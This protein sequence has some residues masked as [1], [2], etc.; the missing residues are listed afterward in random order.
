[1]QHCV[2]PSKLALVY[3]MWSGDKRRKWLEHIR[4]AL[5]C[6]DHKKVEMRFFLKPRRGL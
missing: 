2:L 3:T 6:I 1:M 4:A 5:D